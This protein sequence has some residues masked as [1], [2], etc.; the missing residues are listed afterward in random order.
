MHRPLP[1]GP[2]A[3]HGLPGPTPIAGTIARAPALSH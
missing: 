1:I 2:S 3:R